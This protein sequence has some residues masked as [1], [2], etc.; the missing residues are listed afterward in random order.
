MH[1]Y[2]KL[3][4]IV[5]SA[6]ALPVA[7]HADVTLYGFVSGGY[8]SLKTE[9]VSG[10]KKTLS[11]V[12]DNTSRIGFKGNEDLGNGL[13][14][15]W[16]VEQSLQIDG[17]NDLSTGTLGTRN[18]F[19]GLQGGFGTALLGHY[20]SA[21]KR[22]TDVGLNVM[23]DTAADTHG[24]NNVYSR[25]EARLKNSVHYTSANFSGFQFGAS[26]GFDEDGTKSADRWSLGASYGNGGLKLGLGYDQ[27]DLDTATED[28]TN[29]WKA[30]ASYKFATGTFVGA[31]FERAKTEYKNG[32]PSRTQ[33]DW[34]VA[35]GQDIG[36]LQLVASYGKLGKQKNGSEKEGEAKQW[37]VGANYNLS[38]RTQ[39]KAF[40]TKTDNESGASVRV[41]TLAS[42]GFAA[43]TDQTVYGLGLKHSF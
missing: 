38:K 35:A 16:Q 12:T 10:E 36:N 9:T 39:V 27:A 24:S 15:I 32:N 6:L 8:E 11:R 37:L 28:N 31:G 22:L 40:A 4:L 7:A 2:K 30:A 14:A 13:K 19:V 41:D 43:G 1:N 3:A 25:R 26:Y 18:T 17:A 5:A 21:Y 20:D 33:N 42:T 23:G 29:A 34:L